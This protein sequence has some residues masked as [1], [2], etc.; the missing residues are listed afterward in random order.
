MTTGDAPG[1][2]ERRAA[3]LAA[4]PS[5]ELDR[6]TGALMDLLDTADPVVR[7]VTADEPGDL[8]DRLAAEEPVHPIDGPED[9]ADRLDADRRCFVLEHPFLPSRPLN[10]VWVALCT[11]VPGD[12]SA[13]LDRS[14]PTA[15]PARADTA[16]FY[17]IWSVE[18]GLARIQGGSRLISGAVDELRAELPAL[19]TFVT[20]SPIPGF[21][22]WWHER[23]GGL[24]GPDVDDE[25]LLGGCAR[26][27]TSLRADGRPL[28][29]VARFH[30][31]NGARL[32]AL[33][34]HG[35]RSARG[36]DRSFGIMAN[37]RYEPEDR[38]ANRRELAGG[39]VPRAAPVEA[40]VMTDPAR[41][42][43]YH[44]RRPGDPPGVD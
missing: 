35:D 5:D 21:R 14:A 19:S 38:A 10:V 31:G 28:D 17:S 34:R 32:L 7:R 29:P 30:L 22:A 4:G 13:I 16:A 12:I 20:L 25:V 8:L 33:H 44:P 11:A 15:D 27:L 42:D 3:L 39:H 43:R 24:P 40:L 6:V 26:Y 36:R 18:P 9:L 41:E 23:Q 2:L 37:Y 1:L